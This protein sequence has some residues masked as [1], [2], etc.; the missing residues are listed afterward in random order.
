[1]RHAPD[2]LHPS[3]ALSPSNAPAARAPPGGRAPACPGAARPG[4]RVCSSHRGCG[5]PGMLDG[6]PLIDAHQ[7]PVR[8]PTVKPAWMDWAERFGQP[9]WREAYTAGGE[10]IP[11][12]FDELMSTEGVDHALVICEY[13]PKATGT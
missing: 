4:H 6:R 3:P 12:A 10:I 9:G 13:S 5:R 8:L 7:H 2:D 11:A 1:S